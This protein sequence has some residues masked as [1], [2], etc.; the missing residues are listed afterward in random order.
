MTVPENRR[1]TLFTRMRIPQS[2]YERKFRSLSDTV[3]RLKAMLVEKLTNN[4]PFLEDK[5]TA[6][7]TVPRKIRFTDSGT[8]ETPTELAGQTNERNNQKYSL[9]TFLFKFLYEQFSNFSNLYFLLLAVSQFVPALQVGFKISYIAPLFFIISFALVAEIKDEFERIRKDK[10]A[11][12]T[13]VLVLRAEEHRLRFLARL[14]SAETA[15]QTHKACFETKQLKDLCVGDVLFLRKGETLPADCLLLHAFSEDNTAYIK[16]EQLDGETDWKPRVPA[17]FDATTTTEFVYELPSKEL[18]A[19]AGRFADQE[20]ATADSVMWASTALVSVDAVA[21]VL[22]VGGDTRALRNTQPAA[23]KFG[24]TERELTAFI[25]LMF[26]I[27]LFCSLA[28]VLSTRNY[29]RFPSKLFRYLILFSHMIPMSL[30]LNLDLCKIVYLYVLQADTDLAGTDVRT[31]TIPEE[32]GRVRYLFSDKTGTLTTNEMRFQKAV[33]AP[34]RVFGSEALAAA[35]QYTDAFFETLTQPERALDRALFCMA[36]CHNLHLKASGELISNSPDE[37]AIFQQC[38]CSGVALLARS[39]Q[40]LELRFGSLATTFAVRATVPFD[41]TRKRM[42][43][44]LQREGSARVFVVSKGAESAVGKIARKNSWFLEEVDNLAREGL[45]TMVYAMKT[46]AATAFDA[47]SVESELDIV[48]VTGVEDQLQEDVPATLELFKAAGVR[49]WVLT[50]DKVETAVCV[51][52][53]ARLVGF[54]QPL[55]K[56]TGSLDGEWRPALEGARSS[57]AK[58]VRKIANH[59]GHALVVDG[60]ALRSLLAPDVQR[61]F[62]VAAAQCEAVV[63]CRCS[64]D[65]KAAI[66]GLV[67]A[68]TDRNTLAVGDGG[69]DVSMIRAASV[70]VGLQ[71]KEGRQAA[72]AADYALPAFRKLGKLLLWH[73]RNSYVNLTVLT[74]AVVQRGFLL[75]YVQFLYCFLYF[76]VPTTMFGD[77]MM[78]N[79]TGIYTNFLFIAFYVDRD[80]RYRVLLLYPELYKELQKGRL[81]GAAAVLVVFAEAMFQGAVLLL[82]SSVLF[83]EHALRLATVAFTAAVIAVYANV[84]LTVKKKNKWLWVFLA[85]SVCIYTASVFL[86]PTE[87]DQ[88]FMLSSKFWLKTGCSV[89]FSVVPTWAVRKVYRYFYPSLSSKFKFT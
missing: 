44:A 67:G 15:A 85:L 63:C 77:V 73:G 26:A 21:L 35:A 74:K 84:L 9:Y 69:N 81:L 39:P 3:T 60:E 54:S 80:I 17:V 36:V 76:S 83:Q 72:L 82:S 4:F 89:L 55:L 22:Y 5:G 57:A 31:S 40:K 11:N 37:L 41:S 70:G 50:G 58:T 75:S 1:E 7:D 23:T 6:L 38:M 66:V 48:A 32:L 20:A 43:I 2:K 25:Q 88:R 53:A 14:Q 62:A 68:V 56:V 13:E 79:F 61:E 45:R 59:P 65:Q 33:L 18:Y 8:T 19:F 78:L 46:V 29:S 52:R 34:Q 49:V 16:T 51:A 42:S 27:M 71:G 64:P 47:D 30:R 87:F 86:L 28:V 24:R 10:A 12:T